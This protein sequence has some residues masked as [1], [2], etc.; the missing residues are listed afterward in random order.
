[1]QKIIGA[2]E[3]R[4]RVTCISACCCLQ[5]LGQA[6]V[7]R[8][9]AVVFIL[10]SSVSKSQG[11]LCKECVQC[12]ISQT[13]LVCNLAPQVE[14]PVPSTCENKVSR[15]VAANFASKSRCNNLQHTNQNMSTCAVC[16][17]APLFSLWTVYLCWAATRI[18]PLCVLASQAQEQISAAG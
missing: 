5:D 10:S 14:G 3:D 18:L 12:C 1:M 6:Q 9:C 15:W 7:L 8:C 16:L 2:K 13:R 11:H 4:L 17:H